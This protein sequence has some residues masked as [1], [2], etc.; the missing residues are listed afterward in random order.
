MNT[1]WSTW[2]H[3]HYIVLKALIS[4]ICIMQEANSVHYL[5]YFKY[6]PTP[7]LMQLLV[8]GNIMLTEFCVNQV[9]YPDLIFSFNTN[10]IVE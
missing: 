8:L 10:F 7:W 6:T 2:L 1:T 9:Y 4:E 3:L 5:T